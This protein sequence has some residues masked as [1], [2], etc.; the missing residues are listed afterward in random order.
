MAIL[1]LALR[2]NTLYACN[3][4]GRR[5]IFS[6]VS[7]VNPSMKWS[8]GLSWIRTMYEILTLDHAEKDL[9]KIARS[10]AR[11]IVRR[12]RWLAENLDD[13]TPDLLTGSL[14]GFFKL[15]VSDYRVIKSENTIVIHRIG[16][17][18]EVYR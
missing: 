10:I 5:K 6:M 3:S 4:R 18:R 8:N 11:R 1:T 16:H 14:S 9:E 7:A 15:R 17:R 13:V 2:F 12:V